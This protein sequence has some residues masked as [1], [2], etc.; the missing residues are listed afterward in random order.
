MNQAYRRLYYLDNL[1]VLLIILVILGHVSVTYGPVGFWYYY[2]RTEGISAYLLA[3]FT[4]FIQSFI[5]GLFLFIAAYF[6]PTSYRR[7]GPI[8]YVAGRLKRLGLPLLA[9][10]LI[11]S[12]LLVYTNRLVTG[13]ADAS[14]FHFYWH[15]IIRQGQWITGPLWFVQ[16]LLVFT[17]TYL[18][19]RAVAENYLNIRFKG[20]AIALPSH[21]WILVF[22][23][24]LAAVSFGVRVWFPIGSTTGNLQLSFIPQYLAMFVLGILACG[25]RWLDQLSLKKT[26]PWAAAAIAAVPFWPLVIGYGQSFEEM[27]PVAGGFGWQSF[28][29]SLWEAVVGVGMA[30]GL[31][32]F[33]KR[34]ANFQGKVFKHLS[35]ATYAA[36]IIHPLVILPL[37][38]MLKEVPMGPLPK[39]IAVGLAGVP[40]C[41]GAGILLKKIPGLSGIL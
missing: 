20:P 32:Y 26:L 29:Y 21:P 16:A 30:M 12:P 6:I 24:G 40:L 36:F 1:K 11:I 17:M 19:A 33:F 35:R 27:A 39:F 25:N 8:P 41:F 31:L 38:Y 4:S 9:Y 2:E 5:I 22:V 23:A 18:V 14:F 15:T 28:A 34:K 3:F 13:T 10:V 7:K 37:S